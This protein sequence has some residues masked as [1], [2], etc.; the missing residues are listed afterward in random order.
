MSSVSVFT[1]LALIS[2]SPSLSV[3]AELV[4]IVR[5]GHRTNRI[6]TSSSARMEVDDSSKL[7]PTEFSQQVLS[8]VRFAP[9]LETPRISTVLP[10][11]VWDPSVHHNY[12]DSFRDSCREILLCSHAPHVQGPPPVQ[13]KQTVNAAC[14]LP[15]VLWMEILSYTHRDCK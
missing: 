11:K 2:F 5:V 6:D 12:P 9:L 10:S 15:R 4:K 3:E 8:D 1:D 13:P 7:S 14:L